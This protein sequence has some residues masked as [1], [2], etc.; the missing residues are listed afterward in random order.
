MLGTSLTLPGVA[1]QP[2][3]EMRFY[4]ARRDLAAAVLELSQELKAPKTEV[5]PMSITG[6]E[7][8]AIRARL[9]ALKLKATTRR[10][11]ALGLLDAAD[12][13]LASV[14]AAIEAVAASVEK[15]AADALHEFA[16]HT[17][18]GE[19]LDKTPLPDPPTI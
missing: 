19:V 16:A 2:H 12:A 8:G 7:P 18:G 15:E 10:A 9:D 11:G 4:A 14:D 17:N 13:K 1:T 3:D 6:F 5:S